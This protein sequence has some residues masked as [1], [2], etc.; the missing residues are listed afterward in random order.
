MGC[1]TW[2]F[3]IIPTLQLFVWRTSAKLCVLKQ[4]GERKRWRSCCWGKGIPFVRLFRLIPPAGW[5]PWL[6][7]TLFGF[8]ARAEVAVFGSRELNKCHF[9]MHFLRA[10]LAVTLPYLEVNVSYCLPKKLGHLFLKKTNNNTVEQPEER[11]TEKISYSLSE[12]PMWEHPVGAHKGFCTIWIVQ[13]TELFRI[14][15]KEIK[16]AHGVFE[17]PYG[18]GKNRGLWGLYTLKPGVLLGVFS[19]SPSSDGTRQLLNCPRAP[20]QSPKA[21]PPL[22]EERKLTH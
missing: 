17:V 18:K 12:W 20:L 6:A 21:L 4:K 2:A 9:Q 15:T 3:W 7:F 22:E 13:Q 1:R 19:Y 14:N 16:E 8:Q 11:H 10:S 5:N